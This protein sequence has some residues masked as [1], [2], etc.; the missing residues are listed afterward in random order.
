MANINEKGDINNDDDSDDII[1]KTV[2]PLLPQSDSMIEIY[3]DG[4]KQQQQ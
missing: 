1:Q 3:Q 2:W 4:Q